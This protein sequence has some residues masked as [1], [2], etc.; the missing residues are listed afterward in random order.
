LNPPQRL[1]GVTIVDFRWRRNDANARRRSHPILG[2]RL[3][4]H[5]SQPPKPLLFVVPQNFCYI[6]ACLNNQVGHMRMKYSAAVFAAISAVTLALLPAAYAAVTERVKQDCRGDYKRYC[7]DYAVGSE[8]LRACMSRS[9][10]KLSNMCVAALVDGGEM[11]KA[12]AAKLQKA[13]K[14]KHTTHRRTYRS[15]HR[16]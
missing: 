2:A 8:A 4:V 15:S 10:R 1:G 13:R 9:S 14:T 12:E 6:G 16:H 5:D 3:P 7:N 11:T